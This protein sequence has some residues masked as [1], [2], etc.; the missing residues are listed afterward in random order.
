LEAGDWDEMGLWF[1]L[2]MG[3]NAAVLENG[4][5][6]EPPRAPHVL[7]NETSASWAYLRAAHFDGRPGHAD[8]L[9]LDLWWRG[10]NVAQDAGTYLYNAQ[11]PWDNALVRSDVHNTVTVDGLEQM[12]RAG[13]F[14]YLGWAQAKVLGWEK[15]PDGSWERLTAQHNGYR[16]LGIV[17]QRVVTAKRQGDWLVEDAIWSTQDVQRQSHKICLHWLLPDWPWELHAHAGHAFLL[18]VR[19]PHADVR[20]EVEKTASEQTTTA[21]EQTV[22]APMQV[23]IVRAGELLHG[24]GDVS[25]NWGWV[26]P[27]YGVKIPAL[28]MRVTQSGI[29]PL[30]LRSTWIFPPISP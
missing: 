21:L 20:L 7:H 13:R 30:S 24:T 2:K 15:A 18:N 23:Q 22:I 11:P 1:G 8:Q 27:T 26:S 5:P 16:K 28:S 4:H 3:D 14:L 6:I 12:T 9:H 25:P 10:L 19:T 29:L 17:H